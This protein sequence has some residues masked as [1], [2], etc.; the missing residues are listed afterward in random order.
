MASL[1]LFKNLFK[2]DS[3]NLLLEGV[4]KKSDEKISQAKLKNFYVFF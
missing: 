4:L 2:A 3:Q 1:G